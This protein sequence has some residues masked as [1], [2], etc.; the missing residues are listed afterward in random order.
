M[1]GTTHSMK[2]GHRGSHS[3]KRGHRGSVVIH[4]LVPRLPKLRG[5]IIQGT[6]ITRVFW[7]GMMGPG[8]TGRCAIKIARG[9][10]DATTSNV[11]KN[12]GIPPMYEFYQGSMQFVF[13]VDN[14]SVRL[15][16]KIPK[17]IQGWRRKGKIERRRKEPRQGGRCYSKYPSCLDQPEPSHS[18]SRWVSLMRTLT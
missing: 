5:I 8:M 12:S 13:F 15:D 11:R 16:V 9:V 18:F 4:V 7:R 2:R 17:Y 1:I 10:G 3:I 6:V 14:L